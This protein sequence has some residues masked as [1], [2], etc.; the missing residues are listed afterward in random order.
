MD[1]RF[2]D[3]EARQDVLIGAIT[4]LEE[5]GIKHGDSAPPRIVVVGD[6]S[7]GKSSLIEAI[8]AVPVPRGVG[9]CTKVPSMITMIRVTDED[10][11][12]W[13]ATVKLMINYRVDKE[14]D[15]DNNPLW[16]WV[17][18]PNIK[19]ATFDNT[20]KPEALGIILQRGQ[21]AALNP[22]LSSDMF[23]NMRA[24]KLKLTEKD[25]AKFSP[26]C[27]HVEIRSRSCPSIVLFDLPGI[28]SH[29]QDGDANATVNFVQ[30]LAR[31]YA[32]EE[33]SIVLNTMSMSV[34][35]N[36]NRSASIIEDCGARDR[37]FGVLTKPDLLGQGYAEQW[38][39]IIRGEDFVK[40]FGYYVVRLP[41]YDE[42]SK[43]SKPNNTEAL[44][45]EAR[46]FKD[47]AWAS[48]FPGIEG[49][50]GVENLRSAL[51]KALC[52]RVDEKLP[53]LLDAVCL[54]IES[55]EIELR[56]LPLSPAVPVSELHVLITR[57]SAAMSAELGEPSSDTS[58][59]LRMAQEQLT[60][61]IRIDQRPNMLATDIIDLRGD[62][63]QVGKASKKSRLSTSVSASKKKTQFDS[64]Y[65]TRGHRFTVDEIRNVMH[66]YKNPAF[67]T[68][69]DC[70]ATTVL[71]VRS[72]RLWRETT[73]AFIDQVKAALEN[74]VVNA[75]NQASACYG[76]L[77]VRSQLLPAVEILVQDELAQLIR[78][79]TQSLEWEENSHFILGHTRYLDLSSN[80]DKRVRV[81]MLN[82]RIE[83]WL[84]SKEGI[85][86]A[87]EIEKAKSTR[88]AEFQKK[89]GEEPS[90]AEIRSF[91]DISAYYELSSERIVERIIH[92]IYSRILS[93]LPKRFGD[94]LTHT[95]KLG[96]PESVE[97]A[98]A[99]FRES[100]EMEKER[101]RLTVDLQRLK[102]VKVYIER[103]VGT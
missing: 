77:D 3:I 27:V 4:K 101:A 13:K 50:L 41:G 78:I 23:T 60:E 72:Q 36:N 5:C 14:S 10:E 28:I 75:I 33:S 81:A 18:M 79:A 16:P 99:L 26:N 31:M 21:K 46:F 95:F 29:A 89:L 7:T 51:I 67:P 39:A 62:E 66:I 61:S 34:D 47:A 82:Y 88:Q 56:N 73:F 30:A 15:K 57:V 17:E 48:K 90:V 58:Q 44:E 42:T 102:G 98:A 20:E 1:G 93:G 96:Q 94:I 71:R 65:S 53:A 68:D 64:F 54:Q 97:K 59:K 2:K 22:H 32:Q 87:D 84:K 91:S 19:A 92:P 103:V 6:Q 11:P 85:T 8:A 9:T 63:P 80:E 35:I 86:N 52:E 38:T 40:G 55:V 12:D 70:R 25:E 69:V 37:S 100:P 83:R 76:E 43:T 74:I 45:E 24:E 49:K